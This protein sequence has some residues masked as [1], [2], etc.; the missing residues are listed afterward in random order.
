MYQPL[1]PTSISSSLVALVFYLLM[2]VFTIY[3][4]VA[5]YALLR[6]GRNKTLA[7]AV[8][9]FYLVIAAGLYTNAVINLK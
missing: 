6:F 4:I 3:S 9:I 5:L 1:I 7:I 8:S 2:A